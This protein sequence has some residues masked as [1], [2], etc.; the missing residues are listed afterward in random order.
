MLC[1]E[2]IY[3]LS[4]LGQPQPIMSACHS[5]SWSCCFLNTQIY[6]ENNV[7]ANAVV[8]ST[9]HSYQSGQRHFLCVEAG[10]QLLLWTENIYLGR[11]DAALFSALRFA[12]RFALVHGGVDV[13]L[14]S[15]HSF[16][17]GAATTAA[18]QGL[19]ISGNH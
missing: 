5:L 18:Q 2:I 8:P 12:L 7:S 6:L 13:S 10:F 19:R 14:Y 9:L 4:N 17:V 15:G 11:F 16:R 3:P 1:P